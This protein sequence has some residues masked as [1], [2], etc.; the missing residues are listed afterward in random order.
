MSNF[1]FFYLYV[2]A[3]VTLRHHWKQIYSHDFLVSKSDS[4]GTLK[5][6]VVVNIQKYTGV[7]LKQMLT[8]ISTSVAK[9]IISDG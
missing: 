8:K 1:N 4:C 7:L 5:C 6:V 2:C 3:F 9:F